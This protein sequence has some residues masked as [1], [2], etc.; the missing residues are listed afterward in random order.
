[1]PEPSLS[2]VTLTVTGTINS[3]L[4]FS[5]GMLLL[6]HHDAELHGLQ[7]TDSLAHK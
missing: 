1:M 7:F 2:T 5:A 6:T 3:H 4:V